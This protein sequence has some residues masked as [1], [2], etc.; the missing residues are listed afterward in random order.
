M[1][2]RK[3]NGFRWQVD[4]GVLFQGVQTP[5]RTDRRMDGG[6]YNNVPFVGTIDK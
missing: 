6:N 4:D 1:H 5:S 3:N 2:V